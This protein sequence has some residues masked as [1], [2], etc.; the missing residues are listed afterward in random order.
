MLFSADLPCTFSLR[1]LAARFASGLPLEG[2]SRCVEPI[3]QQSFGG[4]Y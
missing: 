1:V 4:D 2:L 3:A